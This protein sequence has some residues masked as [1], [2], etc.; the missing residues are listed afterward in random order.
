MERWY[1]TSHTTEHVDGKNLL[2]ALK[3]VVPDA[4]RAIE[5][6]DGLVLNQTDLLIGT[7]NRSFAAK[8]KVLS[9]FA[10][11][12]DFQS[13]LLVR[14]AAA[15]GEQYIDLHPVAGRS[16]FL[17]GVRWGVGFRLT[18]LVSGLE[19]T[20]TVDLKGAALAVEAGL[21][22]ASVMVT[23]FG[24]LDVKLLASMPPPQPFT[25]KFVDD[26]EA[27]V[28]ALGDWVSSSA[29]A[30]ESAVPFQVQLT[31]P[32]AD[33]VGGEFR[34]RYF[35]IRG[36]K[37]GDSWKSVRRAVRRKGLNTN[38]ARDTYR[39]FHEFKDDSD[40]PPDAAIRDAAKWLDA[41]NVA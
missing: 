1:S 21:A 33:P 18:V 30:V 11:A 27:A 19:A 37:A 36:I 12:L 26:I 39:A 34:S 9:N 14:E 15:F 32:P 35:T 41:T 20:T 28:K 13:K 40:A 17:T 10:G 5:R 3:G 25:T 22:T 38:I 23:G 24:H 29:T 31:Q 2:W 7:E 16:Q 8:L 4:E 6:P